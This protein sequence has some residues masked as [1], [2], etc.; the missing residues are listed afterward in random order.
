MEDSSERRQA[1]FLREVIELFKLIGFIDPRAGAP[2]GKHGIVVTAKVV[3]E[4]AI[5]SAQV[6]LVISGVIKENIRRYAESDIGPV[7]RA[8]PQVGVR[9]FGIGV[10]VARHPIRPPQV[11]WPTGA[12]Y[13]VPRRREP[14]AGNA[15]RAIRNTGNPRQQILK[16][17]NAD[18]HRA[19]IQHRVGGGQTRARRQVTGGRRV[20]AVRA[21]GQPVAV[22]SGIDHGRDADL[23]QVAL[24]AYLPGAQFGVAQRGQKH[25]RQ[26]RDDGDDHQQFNE[27][28]APCPVH[29]SGHFG[30]FSGLRHNLWV[31]LG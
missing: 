4:C 17:Q 21:H 2:V 19:P 14:L 30:V 15:R 10:W 12:D 31:I 20:V 22:L 26:Q 11:S 6:N 18:G 23:V 29:D 9:A 25:R 5:E 7:H 24:A 13:G 27:G 16:H 1:F 3:F 8:R 28:E